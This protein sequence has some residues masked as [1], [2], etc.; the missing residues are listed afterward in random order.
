M[1]PLLIGFILTITLPAST[2][3]QTEKGRWLIGT[4]FS[5]LTYQKQESGYRSLTGSIIPSAG[6]FIANGLAIGAGIPFSF[7]ATK[8]GES[9]PNFYNLRQNGNAIGLAP[10]VRYYIGPTKLKP[11]MGIA[12]SYSH[13]T[14]KY[15]TGTATESIS[16]TSGYATA[17]TPTIGLAYF[18]T[19]TL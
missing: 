15:K 5:S 1:K 10:F 18:V 17:L 3:A 12:Y 8:Y 19:R 2:Q 7:S 6:Y 11:F 14:S 16:K 13:T 4:Q 9:Y